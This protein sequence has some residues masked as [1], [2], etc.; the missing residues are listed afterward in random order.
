MGPFSY[1]YFAK[2]LGIVT[3]SLP[4]ISKTDPKFQINSHGLALWFTTPVY[5]WLLW[6]R[7]ASF[8]WRSLAISIAPVILMDL[9]YQNSGWLQFGYRFSNDYAVFLFALLAMGGYRLASCS[10]RARCGASQ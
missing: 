3:S 9:L 7:R 1:H 5:L 6:P 2:N 8:V 10:M 4:Y